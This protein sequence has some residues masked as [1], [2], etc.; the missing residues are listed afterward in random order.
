MST[1]HFGIVDEQGSST[2]ASSF[3]RDVS[4]VQEMTQNISSAEPISFGKPI[5]IGSSI[6]DS[7][8][9]MKT[10]ENKNELINHKD[11]LLYYVELHK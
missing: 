7:N 3:Q 9:T 8:G 10:S 2:V 11:A 5:L 4:A 6:K 1:V